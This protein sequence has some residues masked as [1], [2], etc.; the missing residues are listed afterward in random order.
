MD[1]TPERREVQ[2]LLMLCRALGVDDG[3]EGVGAVLGALNPRRAA[4]IAPRQRDATRMRRTSFVGRC[5]AL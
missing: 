1:H 3:L 4:P 2:D 5:M